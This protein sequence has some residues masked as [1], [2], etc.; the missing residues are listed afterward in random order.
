MITTRIRCVPT[1]TAV[2]RLLNYYKTTNN[3][4]D[5]SRAARNLIKWLLMDWISMAGKFKKN[6]KLRIILKKNQAGQPRLHVQNLSPSQS[7]YVSWSHTRTAI[8]CALTQYE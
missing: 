8:V 4:S 2:Y 6:P 3:R 7:F 5:L 1:N